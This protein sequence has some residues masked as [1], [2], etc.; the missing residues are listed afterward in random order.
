LTLERKLVATA[1]ASA[2]AAAGECPVAV[3]WMR[4]VGV[5]FVE[6]V[7]IA[8][9]EIRELRSLTLSLPPPAR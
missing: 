5:E 4:L 1:L 8:S 2:L 6:L 3:S 9:A 7:W